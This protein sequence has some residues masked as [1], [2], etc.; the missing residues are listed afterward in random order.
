MHLCQK[1]GSSH[2]VRV[3]AW[4][5]ARNSLTRIIEGLYFLWHTCPLWRWWLLVY[6]Q[7]NVTCQDIFSSLWPQNSKVFGCWFK[8]NQYK[9]FR[10]VVELKSQYCTFQYTIGSVQKTERFRT[11]WRGFFDWF[12]SQW[13]NF[14][15]SLV[16]VCC[17]FPLNLLWALLLL[18]FSTELFISFFRVVVF[19]WT[20]YK[21]YL[22]YCFPLNF[23]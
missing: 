11:N 15:I 23:L 3:L 17:G 9:F 1:N 5:W 10:E 6:C 18:S 22:C 19:H 7:K 8:M 21:L 13:E 14:L 20:F 16:H 4:C 12:K 2:C